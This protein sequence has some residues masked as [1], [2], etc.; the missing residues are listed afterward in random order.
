MFNFP[1]TDL[2]Y[3]QKKIYKIQSKLLNIEINKNLILVK[4]F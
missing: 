1:F 3:K 2:N 4:K